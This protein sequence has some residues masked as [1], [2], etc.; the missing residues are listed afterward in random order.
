LKA[1]DKTNWNQLMTELRKS[2]TQRDYQWIMNQIDIDEFINYMIL[3]IHVFNDDFP[4]NN[5][6]MWRPRK[7]GGKWR[8]I[9]KDLDRG[10]GYP[11][12]GNEVTRDAMAYNTENNNDERKLFNALLTQDS[13]K[14]KFYGR[15]AVYMG[16][17]L[18]YK[19]TS[20]IIDSI[21]KILEPAMQDHLNH[22]MNHSYTSYG[23]ERMWTRDMNSWRNEVAKMKNWSNGRN[24]NMYRH[25]RDYFKLGT[26]MSLTYGT[27]NDLDGKPNVFINDVRMR[28]SGLNGSYF[29]GEKLE[30]R[31]EGNTPQYGWEIMQIV[32]GVTTVNTY[33]QQELSYQIQSGCTFVNIKLVKNPTGITQPALPEINLLVFDNQ[34]QISDLQLPSVISIYDVSGKLITK[35]TASERSIL[36]P[37]PH[38]RGIFI[39]EV[40]NE[41]QRIVRKV[42][43]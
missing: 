4:G 13:F 28:D 21:Q 8:F 32:N 42:V 39:V 37:F 16:D 40:R 31:Y 24:V 7:A 15:F 3:Q 9:L 33:F 25:L 41:M 17:L 26:I 36:I 43:L 14:K 23:I 27:A 19:S 22:W 12:G 11:W 10:L 5:M 20:Q 29:Q 6:V 1:G 35:T 34:L 18:H 38:Q 2:T 30:L